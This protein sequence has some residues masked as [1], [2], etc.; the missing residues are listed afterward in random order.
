MIYLF[1]II[2]LAVC[3]IIF[4]IVVIYSILKYKCPDENYHLYKDEKDIGFRYFCPAAYSIY[5][6]MNE[7]FNLSAKTEH[8]ENLK[9]IYVGKDSVFVESVYYCKV[10]SY[11]LF[12]LLAASLFCPILLFNSDKE[13]VIKNG[14]FIERGTPTEADRQVEIDTAI[15]QHKDTVNVEIPSE[16]Y[17]EKELNQKFLQAKKYIKKHYL[18]SNK[19]AD[20]V[21]CNLNLMTAIP[22][23]AIVVGWDIDVTDIIS[24]EGI[25][26]LEEVTQPVQAMVTA[27]LSYGEKK[28]S[29]PLS[30]TVIPAKKS[31]EEELWDTWKKAV[32]DMTESTAEERYLK[33]PDK[34]NGNK[35]SYEEKQK[36]YMPLMIAVMFFAVL[37]VPLLINSRL[38][39]KIDDREAQMRHD[40]PEFVEKFVLLI[41]AGLNCKGAWIR[42][43]D[44]YTKK[45]EKGGKS[46]YLYEEMICTRRQFENGMNEASAYEFFGRRIGLINYMKFSTL[47]VQNLKKGSSDLLQILEYEAGD[48][49]KERRENAK[50]AG[51]KAGTK[52][53]LPMMIMLADV[54]GIIIYAAFSQM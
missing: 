46:R 4:F 51:E 34:I 7:H 13:S 35:V 5:Q 36:N 41:S 32:Q 40:Y 15:G 20:K 45:C 27:K 9:K 43:T 6:F 30:I 38:K 26:N 8:L 11:I 52:L 53:L 22:D 18:G 47:I 2:V 14:Y 44:E 48:V 33:L 16:R 28:E 29:V 19:S 25:L 49:L 50:E 39:S 17:S 1:N 10:I 37:L 24:E 54:F 21:N 23:S 31:K 3:I 12:I 42:I